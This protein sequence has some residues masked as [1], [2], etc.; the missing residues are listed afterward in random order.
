[1]NKDELRGILKGG[2]VAMVVCAAIFYGMILNFRSEY[3]QGSMSNEEIVSA[4]R[5]LGMIYVTELQ[6]IDDMTKEYIINMAKGFGMDFVEES[7]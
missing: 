4:A 7:E 3:Q 1:M 6:D 5:E 2:G